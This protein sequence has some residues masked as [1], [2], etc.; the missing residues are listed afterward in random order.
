MDLFFQIFL[1]NRLVHVPYFGTLNWTD[2]TKIWDEK[3]LLFT[4]LTGK[5]RKILFWTNK[6][7]VYLL[8]QQIFVPKITS[9]NI[10]LTTW[11]GLNLPLEFD[12][13]IKA[14]FVSKQ[15]QIRLWQFLKRWWLHNFGRKSTK[16]IW[17]SPWKCMFEAKCS[18][19][20]EHFQ[21]HQQREPKWKFNFT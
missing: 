6:K 13:L 1:L 9:E 10:I 20:H 4:F 15:F 2:I 17:H 11:K 5:L 14:N 16:M 18:L 3:L 12:R 7:F 8:S 21:S 19:F